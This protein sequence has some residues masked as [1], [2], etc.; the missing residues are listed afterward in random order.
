MGAIGAADH[1][2]TNRLVGLVDDVEPVEAL[3]LYIKGIN[4]IP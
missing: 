2:L 4:F 1:N 3:T